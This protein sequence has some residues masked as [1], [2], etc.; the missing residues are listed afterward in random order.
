MVRHIVF[1]LDG[2]L[3]DSLAGIE[4]SVK[5]AMAEA[6]P[7]REAP[8]LAGLVGPPIRQVLARAVPEADD[9]DLDDLV[10]RFRGH[11]DR[12]GWREAVPYAGV[13]EGLARLRAAGITTSVVTNKPAHPAGRILDEL[14]LKDHFAA[15]VSP[16]S[17]SP[18][19]ADKSIALAAH[20][21]NLGINP[22]ETWMVGDGVD[23]ERAARACGVRF[24]AAGYGYGRPDAALR[25]STFFELMTIVGV[26]PEG[27]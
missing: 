22:T 11:Y 9:T 16:D 8:S 25:L 17:V 2:T 14:G 1:D 5:A 21:E 3:I 18:P 19:H 7:G 15:V 27:T 10:S 6:F 13:S 20:L 23:D 4:R 24:I 26:A 12:D